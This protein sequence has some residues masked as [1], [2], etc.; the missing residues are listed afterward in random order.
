MIEWD[1]KDRAAEE[2]RI[3]SLGRKEA[4]MPER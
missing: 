3:V 1:G 2:R 4:G